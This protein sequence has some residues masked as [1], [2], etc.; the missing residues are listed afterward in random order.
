[1][2][3]FER[4]Y[5]SPF[6]L[7]E[8][9]YVKGNAYVYDPLQCPSMHNKYDHCPVHSESAVFASKWQKWANAREDYAKDPSTENYELMLSYVTDTNPPDAPDL[10]VM[11]P[12]KTKT[13]HDIDGRPHSYQK[14]ARRRPPDWLII[15]W[16]L[17][18]TCWVLIMIFAVLF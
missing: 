1:M 18:M 10:V 8:C 15:T 16:C 17:D 11:R 4:E 2:R 3:Q 7:P 5:K 9:N 12:V 13:W 6:K 14:P